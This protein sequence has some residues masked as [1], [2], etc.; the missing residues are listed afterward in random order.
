MLVV[1]AGW[2]GRTL[3]QASSG[4]ESEDY[5][6]VGFVDDDPAKQ[7]TEVGDLPVLG[8]SVHVTA[9]VRARQVDEPV[10]AVTH[11]IR[12]ELFQ[13]LMDWRAMGVHVVR[14]PDLYE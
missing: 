8:G 10:V 4:R 9:L 13:A 3:A 6:A 11:D 5:C 7:G 14:M 12:G 1:G 2:S